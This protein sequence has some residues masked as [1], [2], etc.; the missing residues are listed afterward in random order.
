MIW[1]TWRQ[2]RTQAVVALTALAALS[3]TLAITGPQ[4][5][6]LYRTSGIP[7]CSPEAACDNAISNFI[8]SLG[9]GTRS[10]Y[11]L[12][13]GVMYLTPAVIGLFWGAPLIA[14]EFE[15]GTYRL[16]WTQ[17]VTRAR[18]LAV[19][20]GLL[21]LAAM[22]IAGLL[23]LAI[24]WWAT[25]IDKAHMDRIT[26]LVFGARDIVPIAYAAF[27]FALGVTIGALLRRTVPAMAITIALMAVAQVVTPLWIRPHL[28]APVHTTVA[29]TADSMDGI[30]MSPD[31]NR[32]TIVGSAMIPG[33]WVL[34]NKVV[35][36]AGQEFT[37]PIPAGCRNAGPEACQRAVVDLHLSQ[38]VTYQPASRFWPLQW[39]ESGA[40][41]ILTLLLSGLSFRVIRLRRST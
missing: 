35:N 18:W 10:L 19:K 22:T 9:K 26:P 16:A 30:R 3:I 14:R 39:I 29:L 11:L 23:S 7:G 1:L 36:A 8:A 38:A 15:A 31:A 25:P 37:G 33:M 32:I 5:A 20:L 28:I 13:L 17:S 21:G 6:D 24:T 2:S 27:A 40:Y 41:L 4:I 12:G 34:E